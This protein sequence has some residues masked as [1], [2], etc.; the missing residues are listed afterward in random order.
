MFATRRLSR[1]ITRL[2]DT[3]LAPSGLRA[4]QY[5]LLVAIARGKGESMSA[6]GAVLGMDRTT[7]T[8]AMRSL[9]ERGL[10]EDVAASDA[11]VRRL[12]LTALGSEVTADAV[13]LWEVAQASVEAALGGEPDWRDLNK[14]MRRLNKALRH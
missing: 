2:Y 5:N 7:L 10:V 1:S 9:V 6:L 13:A 14:R 11:R 3:A 12:A 4:T 8:H